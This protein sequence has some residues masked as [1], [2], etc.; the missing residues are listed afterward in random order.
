V[1][2]VAVR[3]P[4]NPP[5]V[6]VGIVAALVVAAVMTHTRLPLVSNVRVGLVVFVVL[7][8]TMCAL[9]GIGRVGDLG[10]WAHPLAILGYVLGGV[11]LVVAASVWLGFSLP[12]IDSE[13][14]AFAV[15]VVLSASKIALA[16][17]HAAL[18][19]PSL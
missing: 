5:A 17:A 9:G 13:M 10:Q 2:T 4:L 6:V 12:Y 15:V 8:M 3:S 18:T 7:G 1:K 16:L 19:R 11:I 14:Q